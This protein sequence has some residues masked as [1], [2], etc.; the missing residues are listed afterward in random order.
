MN[1]K[2]EIAK[3]TAQIEADPDNAVLYLERGKLYNRKNDY[4]NAI[5]DFNKVLAIEPGHV[6]AQQFLRYVNEIL[7]YRYTDQL[8]P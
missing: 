5:N 2:E 4:S 7:D 3:L 8:N 1:N 6:E